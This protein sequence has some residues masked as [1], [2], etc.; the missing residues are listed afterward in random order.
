M[1]IQQG[2]TNAFKT[3]LATAAFDFGAD[4][5]KIALY[6]GNANLGPSTG[7]YTAENETTGAG[8]VAGGKVLTVSVQPTTG[9]N[10]NNTV[11]YLSFENAIW[12]PATF[13]ARGALIYKDGGASVCVLD[14]G[15]DKVATT[16]FE[17]QFPTSGPTTSIIR[18]A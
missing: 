7:A 11:M 15:G 2:A 1:P 10:P 4:T 5:F 3:G 12:D 18:I 8:Y 9:N 14:F 16:K 13:T 17:V 6:D